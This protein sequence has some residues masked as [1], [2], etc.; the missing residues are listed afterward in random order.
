VVGGKKKD[1]RNGEKRN[2]KLS[3][4]PNITSTKPKYKTKD[5]SEIE[6]MRNQTDYFDI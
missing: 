3:N 5:N 6:I 2:K 1:P 4:F